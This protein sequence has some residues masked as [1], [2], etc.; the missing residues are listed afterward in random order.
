MTWGNPVDDVLHVLVHDGYVE[1]RQE[2]YGFVSGLL[3]DWWRIRYVRGS[4][5][6]G[7]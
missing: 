5:S 4:T 2:G 1:R 3:E 7:R 6:T